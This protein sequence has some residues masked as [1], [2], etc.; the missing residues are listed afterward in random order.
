MSVN[1][2]IPRAHNFLSSLRWNAKKSQK[3]SLK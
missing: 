1:T 2:T 3:K